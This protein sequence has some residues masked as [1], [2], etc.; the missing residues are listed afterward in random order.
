MEFFF[1]FLHCRV[2]LK[3]KGR[4]QLERARLFYSRNARVYTLQ[5]YITVYLLGRYMLT[6]LSIY[7]S[8][9]GFDRLVL[10][11]PDSSVRWV[12][13]IALH[14]QLTEIELVRRW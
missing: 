14:L 11:H 4:C 7:S 2:F 10:A 12:Q 5:Y 6:L 1:T 3:K 9:A 8:V 13:Y